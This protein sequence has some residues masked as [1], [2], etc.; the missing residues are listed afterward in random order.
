[1]AGAVFY[2]PTF[3]VSSFG[4]NNTTQGPYSAKT[5]LE[6]ERYRDLDRRQAYA[7][8]THN[9]HKKYDFNGRIVRPGPPTSQPLLSSANLQVPYYV[10]LEQRRPSSPYRLAKMIRDAFTGLIFGDDRFPKIKVAGDEDTQDWDTAL[11]EECSLATK[12]IL[13]R[14]I[15]GSV[16]TVGLSWF[17]KDG[18]PR[19]EVHNGKNLYVQ[20]WKD[21][22]ELIPAYIT[23]TYRYFKDEKDPSNRYVRNWYWHRRDWTED[24]SIAY[25]DP[26]F[27]PGKEPLWEVDKKNSYP[28]EYGECLFVWIQNTPE[29]EEDGL[30]DYHGLYESCDVL[31][32]LNSILARGTILNLDPTLKLKVDQDMVKYLGIKKGSD[33]ALVVG[34]DGDAE[35]MELSGQSVEAGKSLFE[36]KRRSAL[37]AAQC[38]IPDPDKVAA[39]GISAVAIKAMYRPM[40]GQASLVRS[41]Y[42]RGMRLLLEQMNRVSQATHGKVVKVAAEDGTESEERQVIEL[43]P[44]YEDEPVLDEEDNPTGER[45][46]KKIE[47][48]PGNGERVSFDWPPWFPPTPDDRSKESATLQVA[49]GG[50][51]FLSKETAVE[52]MATLFGRE[53]HEE[54]RR[55]AGDAKKDKEEKS[56][57]FQGVG[58][59]V[60]DETKLPFGAKPKKPPFGKPAEEGEPGKDGDAKPKDEQV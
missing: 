29:D 23:E 28:H 15:G 46:Q 25:V 52:E 13:A 8:C 53:A 47:R 33:N 38:V 56:Q 37:E 58:G 30:P 54:L 17:L 2:P 12:M 60:D 45:T 51:A 19:V 18:R 34:K 22:A 44:R 24:G 6:S 35:Y 5:F 1:M 40:L 9:D 11:A 10:P 26:L 31:D 59:E 49:T 41:Q 4:A 7:D 39:A 16:G 3:A 36:M 50:K 14:N 43:P 32:I 20:E 57:M 55:M 27:K 21:R 42:T 48:K